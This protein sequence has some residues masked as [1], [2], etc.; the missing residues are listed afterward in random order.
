[1]DASKIIIMPI[2]YLNCVFEIYLLFNFLLG[3][4]PVREEHKGIRLLKAI[5]CITLI[6]MING[7]QLPWVNLILV[8]II[9]FVFVWLTFRLELKYALLYVVFYYVV[10]AMAEFAVSYLYKLLEIDST[11]AELGRIM[12]LIMQDLFQF[13]VIELV[14]RKHHLPYQIDSFQYLKSLFILSLTSLIL[15]NG[16]LVSATHDTIGYLLICIGGILLIFSNMVNFSIVETLLNALNDAKDKE[17]LSLKTHLEQQHYLS[18]Q[19]LNEDYAR[20]IHEME[21]LQRTMKQ[22]VCTDDNE[23]VKSLFDDVNINR[24][25]IRKIYSSDLIMNAIL[26]EREKVAE[27]NGINYNLDIQPGINLKFINDMDKITMFG[28]LLDNAMEAA[29]REDGYVSVSLYMGNDSMILFRVENN[30]KF[31]P[32]KNGKDYLTI[33]STKK[34]HGFGLKLVKD[35]SEKYGGRLNVKENETTFIAT[36]M[37]SNM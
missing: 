3:L 29:G 36:L 19:E 18:L 33:K 7:F 26:I 1:M 37:L 35:L 22:L 9:F 8:P 34:D 17:I 16:F 28:N 32:R 27:N 13:F 2:M 30:F 11:K 6:F 12:I 14:K 24:K 21:R 15:I 23:K 10:M 5:F 25:P 20:Y 31:K 4:F